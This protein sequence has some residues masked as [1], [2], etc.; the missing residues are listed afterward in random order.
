MA[1]GA[2]DTI[3]IEP[4]GGVRFAAA[5]HRGHILSEPQAIVIIALAFIILGDQLQ[6]A[7]VVDLDRPR[8]HDVQTVGVLEPR[9]G[10]IEEQRIVVAIV[11]AA[12][13]LIGYR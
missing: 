12:E 2:G 8:S 5:G 7:V 13:T 11:P 9:L 3:G 4:I 6:L 10:V 1:L